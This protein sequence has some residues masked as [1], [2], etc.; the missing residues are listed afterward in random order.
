MAFGAISGTNLQYHNLG[1]TFGVDYYLKLYAA[2]TSTPINMATDSTGSTLLAKAK[3]GSDGN[4]QTDGGSI[5]SPHIDQSYKFVIYA[6]SADAD[7]N[8]PAVVSIDNLSVTAVDAAVNITNSVQSFAGS[9]LTTSNTVITLTT[10][11]Y[12]P[13]IEN[14]AVYVNGQRQFSGSNY[15]ETSNSVITLTSSVDDND[16]V[17]V[18]QSETTTNTAMTAGNVSYTHGGTGAVPTNVD[19]VFD[20]QVINVH[21]FGAIGDGSTDD[22]AAIQLAFDAAEA[23]NTANTFVNA[24]VTFGLS[25]TYFVSGLVTLRDTNLQGNGSTLLASGDHGIIKFSGNNLS[26]RDL[27]VRYS[28]NTNNTAREG[29]EL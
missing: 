20:H 5:F 7:A 6:S 29:V 9:D 24:T 2:G 18:V 4:L 11:T 22:K 1:N 8:T 27:R 28:T 21:H 26:H 25:K 14:V 3:Y 10:F 19:A 12:T 13:G 16:N 23:I 17:D 15:T